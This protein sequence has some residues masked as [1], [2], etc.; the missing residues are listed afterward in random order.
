MAKSEREPFAHE[1]R[2]NRATRSRRHKAVACRG[3]AATPLAISNLLSSISIPRPHHA[4][5]H[6]DACHAY[7]LFECISRCYT[8]FARE[9][10]SRGRLLS[11][12]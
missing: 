9:L 4:D 8:G 3:F 12:T 5:A 6:D 2:L 10:T 7:F 1:S 11:S